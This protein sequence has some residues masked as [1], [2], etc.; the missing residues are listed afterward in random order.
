MSRRSSN[1]QSC[2]KG[3]LELDANHNVHSVARLLISHHPPEHLHRTLRVPGTQTVHVCS[4]CLGMALGAV[5]A[6]VAACFGWIHGGDSGQLGQLVPMM[7]L[8]AVADFHGQLMHR[9]ESTNY[10]RLVSGGLFGFALGYSLIAIERGNWLPAIVL[11][12][13]L[14]GYFAWLASGRRRVVRLVQHLRRYVAYYERC[15]VEDAR[16][17]SGTVQD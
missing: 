13:V 2:S 12:A 15:R 14:L 10:R 4:R 17:A 3:D 7:I 9:W 16:R 8:P 6:M 5:F 1:S 11:V